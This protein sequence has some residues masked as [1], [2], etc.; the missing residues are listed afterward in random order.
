MVTLEA[1]SQKM[2]LDNRIILQI[3]VLQGYPDKNF[4]WTRPRPPT[5]S[6]TRGGQ[7]HGYVPNVTDTPVLPSLG[8]QYYGCPS[9]SAKYLEMIQTS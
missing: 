1:D 2:Y 5:L 7:S 9:F 3:W 4:F 6:P 8:V